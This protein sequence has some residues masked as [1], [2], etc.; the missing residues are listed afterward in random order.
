MNTLKSLALLF[1]IF[2]SLTS[3]TFAQ[4]DKIT[5][6]HITTT[7]G[8]SQSNVTC[9]L[10]DSQ[11]FMWFGTQ[12]GL[13]MYD[14]YT[15][16]VYRNITGDSTSLSNNNIIS[17]IEDKHQNIWI[18]TR[19]G[20]VNMLNRKKN[21]FYRFKH[22]SS[23]KNT[24]SSDKIQTLVE[25]KQGKIWIATLDEGLCSYNPERKTFTSYKN[26]P[27]NLNS[28]S[29]NTLR[30]LCLDFNGNL[31]IG[32]FQ[33]GA[34]YY[35]Q[36]TKKFTRYSYHG[37][38]NGTNGNFVYS[39]FQDS[40]KNM[41]FAQDNGDGASKFDIKTKTF[42]HYTYNNSNPN[43]LSI[44]DATVVSEGSDGSIWIGTRNGG[45]NILDKD[46]RIT[47]YMQ[48]ASDVR[49]L[50]NNSIFAIYKDHTGNM[51][52]G[53]FSGGVNFH[54]AIKEK[55]QHYK[56]SSSGTH[57]ISHNEILSFTED[58]SGNIWIGTDGGGLNKFNP[59]TNSFTSFKADKKN[60]NNLQDNVLLSVLADRADNIWTGSLQNGASYLNQRTNKFTEMDY[61]G[62]A[63]HPCVMTML[64]DF[65]GNIW[66]GTWEA[67]VIKYN[68]VT[69]DKKSYKRGGS[70]PLSDTTISNNIIL[71]LKEDRNHNIW[72]GT[73]SEGASMFDPLTGKFIHYRHDDAKPN[74]LSGNK[75]SCIFEDKKGNLWIG[76]NEGLNLFN[77]NSKS[78]TAYRVEN[79][80]PNNEIQAILEDNSGNLW[81]STNKGI[82]R[83]NP[84]KKTFRN[85]DVSDGLQGNEFKRD[86][87]FKSQT[88]EMYFGGTNGFNRFNPDSLGDNSSLPNIALTG[89]YIFNKKVAVSPGSPLKTDISS[90]KEITLSYDQSVLTFEFAA[91]NF[92][93]P[94]KNQ[95]A[96]KLVNFDKDWNFVGNKRSATY[97]N[98]DPGEY[99]LIIKGSNNDGYWNEK[100]TSIK[101]TIT[102][103]FWK[104][105]WF[106]IL[107]GLCVAGSVYLWYKDHIRSI[108][109][110]K[111]RLER[112]VNERT[113]ELV[114][115][116]EELQTQSEEL[117]SQSEEL[118]SQ[119]EHLQTLNGELKVK[120]LEAENSRQSA[121]RANQA[122]SA[123]LAT[124]SHEIR[125]PMNGVMG[126]A[127]LLAGTSLDDEQSE[128][129]S[130]INTS[131]D[132]LLA[133]IN[134]ILDFSKIESGNM[135]L[136]IQDFDLRQCVENVLDV[137]ANKAAQQG[138][139][140][141]YQIDA[142]IPSMIVGDS[143]RLRQILLN[144]VSNAMKFTH[145]GEVFVR[146]Y[147]METSGEE[148]QIGFDVKDTGIGIPEDK[149]SRLFKAFSQVDSSTTRKYGG[150][151]L[152]LVI[153]ERLVKLMG[154]DVHV[155]SEEGVG[156]TFGFFIKSR[157]ASN[158]QRTYVA[159]STVGNEGKNILVVDDNATNLSILKAQ[160]E[161]WKLSPTM[162]SSGKQALA[163]LNL[164]HSF[165]LIISDMQMPEMD[166]VTLATA[167]KSK[168]P[169][170]PIILL[171]S[172]GDE[173]KS[174]YPHLFNSVLTKPIKQAQLNKL[175]Q[176][177]L[178][179]TMAP[180]TEEKTKQT[181]LSADFAKAY[182]LNILIAEDNL[183]NQKLAMR[184]L[185]KLGYDPKI[186]NNG[187]EAV[188][189][190]TT[191]PFDV[192]LMDMLMPEMDG[193][194]AT[195][196]IRESI[197]IQQPQIVAMTAN[198]LPEDRM[199][200][201]EAGM[202]DYISKP[203]K[204]EILMDILKQTA[205]SVTK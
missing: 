204:L 73:D 193:I 98:L 112:E 138:L 182:P 59:N 46:G 174:K 168:W 71:K 184:V 1:L 6:K 10:E 142:T 37:G 69:T 99:T 24:V 61:K 196:E 89:F 72:I 68:P 162:A 5:F 2:T 84:A 50:N 30:S 70:A 41:W 199:A 66:L 160:L 186:A 144:F 64:E 185:N 164:D 180:V 19:T 115:K 136:E 91:L 101:I 97:T 36:Q 63:F 105:W 87:G 76:T 205:I 67:G 203:I 110:Q 140:L 158:S 49:G 16:T 77:K 95:Y 170:I 130:I 145:K 62:I 181:I 12:D 32:T 23:I 14:G 94:E 154:G 54:S 176:L 86:A 190:Q 104:T 192:I 9:I 156:T 52:V 137:F 128:Y 83:F 135:D 7:E 114:H 26:I 108:T 141:I 60:S 79:G 131:G 109:E 153:S 53:T 38:L 31:W 51:W 167:I 96:Y 39:I 43:S 40:R 123:F 25:D 28:L 178:K 151:G 165:H 78:F 85:Y 200:C 56:A 17:I 45:V 80:L 81:L 22:S 122:K 11:G 106:R 111:N 202:D 117:Q 173:S 55:F 15:M 113:K 3:K 124:M 35:N 177:E 166:G 133:V 198:A 183:I 102:P 191:Q 20:G 195:K 201:L 8:L 194:Q 47:Y 27:G 65:K 157:A 100:G 161:L 57:S 197:S 179:Q 92:V 148:L 33:T 175:I 132:A 116:T 44:G 187:K 34:N 171:S 146:V 42:S 163:I 147:L 129:V 172:V 149:L 58:K 155:E 143:L 74:S 118:K 189:M 82:S 127:S 107:A 18:G 134:D 139:D 121:D 90:T 159:I 150:T 152:G 93:L 125:T 169:A 88:G 4:K 126:M 120:S 75:V 188:E 21:I 48:D 29:E 119:S 13:N 103:P